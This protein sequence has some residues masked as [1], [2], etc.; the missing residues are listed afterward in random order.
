MWTMC[1]NLLTCLRRGPQ[2]EEGLLCICLLGNLT[3][4]AAK[5]AGNLV[6]SWSMRVGTGCLGLML[7]ALR[8]EGELLRVVSRVPNLVLERPELLRKWTG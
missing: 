5:R 7:K 3:F 1:C 8:E 6:A 4:S 2:T